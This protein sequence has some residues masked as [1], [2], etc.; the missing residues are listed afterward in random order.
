[1]V[2]DSILSDI[3]VMCVFHIPHYIKPSTYNAILSK[4]GIMNT[5]CHSAYDYKNLH[6]TDKAIYNRLFRERQIE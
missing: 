3:I 1:M 4:A 5:K 6:T 2:R